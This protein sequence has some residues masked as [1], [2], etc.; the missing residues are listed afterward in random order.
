MHV[1]RVY[2]VETPYTLCYQNNDESVSV[3]IFPVPISYRNSNGELELIN[4]SLTDVMD[5]NRKDRFALQSETGVVTSLYPHNLKGNFLVVK[6]A[7]TMISFTVDYGQS[8]EYKKTV[9]RDYLGCERDSVSYTLDGEIDL[10]CVPVSFGMKSVFTIQKPINN[11]TISFLLDKQAINDIENNGNNIIITPKDDMSQRCVI[12]CSYFEDSTGK[13]GFIDRITVRET[14]DT[15]ECIIPANEA[16]LAR[17]DIF[18]PVSFSVSF[19]VLPDSMQTVNTY[20]N[21]GTDYLSDY[22]VIGSDEHYG[23][24]AMFMKFRIGHF[25]KTYKQNVKSASLSFVNMV[26]GKTFSTIRFERLNKWWNTNTPFDEMPES[27]DTIHNVYITDTGQYK[28]DITEYIRFCIHDD[29]L[30]TENYGLVVSSAEGSSTII[31][32]YNNA[33]Y[34]PYVR[35]D[36]YDMPWKFEK[37]DEI[38]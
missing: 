16:F 19:E 25:L 3:Y 17:N 37:V 1:N 31:S 5:N 30:N 20:T 8:V 12:R 36:F 34:P 13:L 4:A 6:D 21:S 35:I 29:T 7:K 11:G 27:T 24:S 38:N 33:L 9:F 22:S 15:V 32:N 2:D 14:T 28:V 23:N 26:C 18:Y 10:Q